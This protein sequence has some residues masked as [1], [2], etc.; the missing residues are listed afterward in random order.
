MLSSERVPLLIFHGIRVAPDPDVTE[1]EVL[2][3]VGEEIGYNKLAY[4]SHT[5]K[6]VAV[7][8]KEIVWFVR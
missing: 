2:L 8:L 6:A 4:T 5:N 3:A 1:E 7:F